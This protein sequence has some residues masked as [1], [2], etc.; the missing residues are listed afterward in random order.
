MN[1]VFVKGKLGK[2]EKNVDLNKGDE[3]EGLK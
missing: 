3:G 2:I 1:H